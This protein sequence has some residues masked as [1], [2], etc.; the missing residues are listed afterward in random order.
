MVGGTSDAIRFQEEALSLS[1]ISY[2]ALLVSQRVCRRFLFETNHIGVHLRS[3]GFMAAPRERL[4]ETK[5]SAEGEEQ[6]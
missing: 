6:R 1:T 5:G 4:M 2:T 3:L